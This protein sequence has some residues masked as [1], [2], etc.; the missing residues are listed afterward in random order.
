M[1]TN[2]ILYALPG[3]EIEGQYRQVYR[4]LNQ[5]S[6]YVPIHHAVRGIKIHWASILYYVL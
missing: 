3:A 4:L 6:G 5:Q 1:K 2:D